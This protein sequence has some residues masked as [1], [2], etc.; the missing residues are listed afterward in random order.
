MRHSEL[1]MGVI[2]SLLNSAGLK[3]ADL[4]AAACMKGPG[5]FTGLR[6]AYAAAKGFSLALGIPL[7]SVST[8]DCLAHSR[9]AWPGIVLPA[10][11]AKKSRFFAALYRGDGRLSDYLDAEPPTLAQ[12]LAQARRSAADPVARTGAGGELLLPHL[13]ERVTLDAF[14]RRG[15]APELLDLLKRRGLDAC[16]EDD[17]AGPVYLRK[18]DAELNQQSAK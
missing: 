2:D 18:S 14:A 16:I 8:L 15:R 13:A 5:S 7:A 9:A 3:P 1:L 6:I 4:E 17:S 11:D 12:A 10:L